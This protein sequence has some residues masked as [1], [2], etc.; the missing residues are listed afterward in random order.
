MNRIINFP[1]IN[2][3]KLHEGAI[4]KEMVWEELEKGVKFLLEVRM[5]KKTSFLAK[6]TI[7]RAKEVLGKMEELAKQYPQ[8]RGVVQNIFGRQ[9]KETSAKDG[10]SRTLFSRLEFLIQEAVFYGS[11]TEW[12]ETDLAK[13]PYGLKKDFEIRLYNPRSKQTRYFLPA[14]WRNDTHKRTALILRDLSFKARDTYKAE[15][16]SKA[17]PIAALKSETPAELETPKTTNK[18]KGTKKSKPEKTPKDKAGKQAKANKAKNLKKE[19]ESEIKKVKSLAD[20]D[21]LKQ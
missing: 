1:E 17:A 9:V 18:P 21:F 19:D 11:L 7:E 20:L 15:K 2:W 12:T 13:V 8:I 10:D 4:S 14:S 3:E 16:E 5:L 6:E